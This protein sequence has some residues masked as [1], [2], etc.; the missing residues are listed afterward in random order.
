MKKIIIILLVF[1]VLIF[2]VF[3]GFQIIPHSFSISHPKDV[4]VQ[5]IPLPNDL[6]PVVEDFY[7]ILYGDSIPI[8]DSV[9][10][11]G[12]ATMRLPSKGG[13]TLPGRFKFIHQPGKDYR[14]YIEVTFFGLPIMKV[15][16]LYIDGTSRME[17]PFGVSEGKKVDQGA[18]LALWAEAIWFPSLWITDPDACWEAI[19]E[20][21]AYLIVPFDESEEQILV[22]FDPKTNLINSLESMRYKAEDSI[23]KTKWLNYPSEWQTINGYYLPL[24]GAITWED[25]GTPW[26]VF[27]M[28]DI[29]YNTNVQDQLLSP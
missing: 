22:T 29:S 6:P 20:T 13:V 19:D 2:V 4:I 15:N 9:V 24:V 14:H 5:T 3:I 8:I 11:S 10:I 18:N 23:E 26:A 27:S 21:S 25:E 17:L 28:E 1:V 12:Q 16:E 7:R